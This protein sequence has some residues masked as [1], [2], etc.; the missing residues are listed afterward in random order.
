MKDIVAVHLA[1]YEAPPACVA[2]A[3]ATVKLLGEH[4]ASN[5]GI[6]LAAAISFEMKVAVSLRKD[7]SMRFLAA[8]LGERKRASSS[9]LKYKREDRWANHVKS[10][11]DHLSK[12]YDFQGKGINVTIGG[13]VPQG[14]GLG[15]SAAINMATALALKTLFSLTIKNEELA[16]LACK[17]QSAFLEQQIPIYD[18]LSCIG[19]GVRSLSII[20]L[21]IPR[22]RAVQF[23][24]ESWNLVL[25][26]SRVPRI[27]AEAELKQRSEDCRKCLQYLAPRGGKTLRDVRMSELDD[28]M[29][30]LPE[31]V[32]RRCIHIVEETARVLEAEDALSRQDA[33]A[34]GRIVNKSHA[35]LRNHYE[36]SCPEVDWLVKRSLEI[37]G[38]LCS[39]MTGP[40]FGGCVVSV[41]KADAREEFMKRLEEYERIFGF[42]AHVYE[43][44]ITGGM[45]LYNA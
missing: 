21:R 26:D 19:P 28:L 34:F 18:Y 20:D 3:P 4:T 23:L 9:T 39:R 25:T 44:A 14:L 32:R 42:K 2:S 12:L 27:S 10:V 37:E 33:P 17:A 1:E 38:V 6:V 7:S 8:D 43:T 13:N 22:R 45:K 29:G 41:M 16:E 35:S 36:I 11:Y 31:S 40:G 24:D 5:D 15:I 30:I